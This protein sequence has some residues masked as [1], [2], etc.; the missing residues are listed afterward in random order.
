VGIDI[1]V[2]TEDALSEAVAVALLRQSGREYRVWQRLRR[3]GFGYLKSKAHD[4]NQM[5]SRGFSVLLL[6]D[7]DRQSCAPAL[8]R[9]W[10]PGPISERLLFRV[11]VREVESW[12]IA[13]P[14]GLADFLGIGRAKIPPE[15]DQLRE[16]KGS[17]LSLVKNSRKRGLRSEILPA[18][19][20]TAPVGLGYNLQWSRFVRDHWSAPRAAERSPSLKRAWVRILGFRG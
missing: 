4:F 12:L 19:G 10:L 8:Q 14:E 20:S 17:L 7:L 13:D 1:T 2:A 16:A 11:A 6:T 5:A 3:N 15:P 9:D 18:P